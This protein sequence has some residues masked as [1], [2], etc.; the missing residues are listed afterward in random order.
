MDEGERLVGTD[1]IVEQ[2][3][4][5]GHFAK[6]SSAVGLERIGAGDFSCVGTSRLRSTPLRNMDEV[7]ISDDES[8]SRASDDDF[9]SQ[10]HGQQH[11]GQEKK[12]EL[13]PKKEGL[14]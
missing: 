14:S 12:Q 4:T 11:H 9:F 1:A 3:S 13:T 7:P 5:T 8:E 10:H 2:R 6:A